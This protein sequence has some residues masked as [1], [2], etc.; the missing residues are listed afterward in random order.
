MQLLHNIPMAHRTEPI[1]NWGLLRS[2][3]PEDE[4]LEEEEDEEEES[5]TPIADYQR[6]IIEAPLR[7]PS[8]G[9][10]FPPEMWHTWTPTP[11]R[12]YT[13]WSIS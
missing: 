11:E 1:V 2:F 8:D 9:M 13:R 10:R 3:E 5:D 6:R 7:P 12:P 4:L